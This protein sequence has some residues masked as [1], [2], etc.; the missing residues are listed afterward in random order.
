VR[1]AGEISTCS[2]DALVA[3]SRTALIVIDMQRDFLSSSGV[4]AAASD[5]VTT[6]AGVLGQVKA[7]IAAAREQKVFII[8]IQS[9]YDPPYLS[10]IMRGQLDRRGLRGLCQSD[11]PGSDFVE[12]IAPNG[13]ANECVV[14]KHR[15]SA[16]CG[17]DMDLI[18]RSNGIETLILSGVTT[19]VCVESTARDGFFLGYR[20]VIAGDCVS[21]FSADWH[22]ASLAVLSRSFGRT[23]SSSDIVIAWRNATGEMRGWSEEA[24]IQIKMTTLGER[25]KAAHTALILIDLQVDFCDDAGAVAR[26]N[27]PRRM[28]SDM[29]PCAKA[30]LD[31]ARE[32]GVLIIHVRS[33]Y[34]LK[35]RNAG[36]PHRY[37]S[38]GSR[39]RAVWTESAADLSEP[40][41]FEA[42]LTEICLPGTSGIAFIDDFK[43][44]RGELV[45]TKHRF[46]A[47]RD[48]DLD[49][50]LRSNR[51]RTVIVAGQTTNCCVEST[52]R[53]VAMRD[54]YL[55]I[56]E[57]C[58]A[59]KDIHRDL[60]VASLETMRTYFGV[61]TLSKKIMDIWN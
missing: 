24:K 53:E 58:V 38:E 6:G 26:R 54:Y 41:N 14:I 17:T 19:D 51:I 50:I 21:S 44:L 61:V 5:N 20:V 60:H 4:C 42:S 32:A 7:L 49:L 57:D 23:A 46:S 36:S 56:P 48:T 34:G 30:L 40:Q 33:E 39:E 37:P 10:D 18:L 1:Q 22:R 31:R 27:E 59:V 28:I 13:A 55:I 2:L 3:P 15:F 47:F 45:V 12:G 8:Y 25:A 35:V 11:S 43:P 9:I 52:A 16:F 29:L